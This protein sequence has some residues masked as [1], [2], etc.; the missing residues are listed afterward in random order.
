MR[1]PASG[2]GWAKLPYVVAATGGWAEP[3]TGLPNA[4]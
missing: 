2:F 4:P 3:L 1:T